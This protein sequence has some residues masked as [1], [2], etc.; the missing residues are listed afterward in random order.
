MILVAGKYKPY[1]VNRRSGD[2][3]K[4]LCK[5]ICNFIEHISIDFLE[6]GATVNSTSYGELLRQYPTH[7]LNDP[8]VNIKVIK[9]LFM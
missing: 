3:Q 4:K 8:L 5:I 9:L 6:K 7:L 1:E 2:V